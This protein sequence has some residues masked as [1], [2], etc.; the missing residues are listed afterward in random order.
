MPS[1]TSRYQLH[2]PTDLGLDPD[3]VVELR[4]RA[5]REVDAGLLPSCQLAVAVNGRLALFETFGA[6]SNE[7]RYVIFSTTKGVTAGAIWLLISDGRLDVSQPVAELIPEFGTNGKEGVTVEQL[8]VHTSGFPSAPLDMRTITTREQ[9]LE[10]Y[11]EWRL[12]WEPGSRFEY[13]PTSAHWVLGDII[14]AITGTDHRVFVAE[15]LMAPLGL[16]RFSMGEAPERQGDIAE[17]V[18]VGEPPTAAELEAVTGIPGIDLSTMVGEVTTDAL[19]R[20]NDP[21]VRETGAPG[22]GGISTAADIAL[23]YQALLHNDQGLWD[24]RVL[25]DASRRVRCD[26]PDALR[27]IPSHRSLGMMVAGEG[28]TATMRGFGHGV[29]PETFGHDGA[30]GQIAWADPAT[31]MSFCYLTNGIDEHLI[32]QWRRS[33]GLSSRAAACAGPR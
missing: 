18:A 22:A 15:Q 21:V 14:H 5:R 9:R 3:K 12:N 28:P 25:V 20:F 32:R 4:E 24:E 13:H 1:T 2:E 23:Y 19:L 8:L 10:R 6:A 16:E 31:G 7:N 29:S 11:R 33:V 26:L 30:A 27:G 17:L